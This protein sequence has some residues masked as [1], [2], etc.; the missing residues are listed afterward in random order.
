MDGVEGGEHSAVLTVELIVGNAN[1]EEEEEKGEKRAENH[2]NDALQVKQRSVP[3][4]RRLLRFWRI[5][6]TLWMPRKRN[7]TGSQNDRMNWISVSETDSSFD[8]IA[9][10]TSK[11]VRSDISFSLETIFSNAAPHPTLASRP[12]NEIPSTPLHRL[13]ISE[14]SVELTGICSEAKNCLV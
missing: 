4:T 12:S 13:M 14:T 8:K 6:S 9:C 1:E 10:S 3:P 2:R 5:F 7:V 11:S